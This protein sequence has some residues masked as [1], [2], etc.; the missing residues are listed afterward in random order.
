MASNPWEILANARAQTNQLP[1]L[2]MQ[3]KHQ[4]L[5][6]MYQQ[7]QM[8]RQDKLDERADKEYQRGEQVRSGLTSAYDPSTG[9]IDPAKAR[10]AFVGAG[11]IEGAMKFDDAELTRK[12]NE[13]KT[14][15]TINEYALQQL[16]GVRDQASYDAARAN[17]KMMFDQYG[18]GM[19]F[20]QLPDVYDPATIHKL[21][22]G[23]LSGKEQLQM[24]MEELKAAEQQRHNQATEATAR[25]N[26]GIAAT[27][28]RTSQGRLGVAQQALK[29]MQQKQGGALMPG[30][31]DLGR[32]L[33]GNSSNN[34]MPFITGGEE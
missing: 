12:Q 33:G 10:S 6:D 23:A 7:K 9:Q 2:Y 27:N 8:E 13:L 17:V 34:L 26:T 20:P 31:E 14:Y 5:S 1:A 29:T 30:N 25:A 32:Y 28:A 24:Q 22:M 15:Q 16:G 19:H 18:H 11:D 21:Q 4:R 3:M